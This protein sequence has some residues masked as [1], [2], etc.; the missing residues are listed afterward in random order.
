MEFRYGAEAH[1]AY[2]SVPTSVDDAAWARYVF[3][4][5]NPRGTL[6]ERWQHS[7]GCRRWFNLVRDTSTNDI[8]G[9]YRIGEPQPG[10]NGRV[11]G[12]AI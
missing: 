10:L 2:P 7:G 11:A 6:C 4:R 12:E 3:F 8:L 1:V 5:A 9:V